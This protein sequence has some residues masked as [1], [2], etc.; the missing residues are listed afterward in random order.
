MSS[1]S[2]SASCI[3]VD[4]VELLQVI[5]AALL[6]HSLWLAAV[7]SLA[8]LLMQVVIYPLLERAHAAAMR[9]LGR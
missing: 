1:P 3:A 9:R 2:A 4:P 6:V 7:V 5:D 8:Y